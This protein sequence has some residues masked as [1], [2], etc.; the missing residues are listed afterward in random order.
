MKIAYF[1]L[2]LEPAAPKHWLEHTS[3]NIQHKM[4]TN[5]KSTQ[6]FYFVNF[7]QYICICILFK[8]CETHEEMQNRW[9]TADCCLRTIK[10][11]S[12]IQ[13]IIVPKKISSIGELLLT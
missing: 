4:I 3:H 11:K 2:C 5:T 7:L 9:F 1:D 12:R 13:S 10:S 6:N 8:V